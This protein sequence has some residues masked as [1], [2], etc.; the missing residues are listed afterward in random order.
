VVARKTGIEGDPKQAT[1]A[2]GR[3]WDCDKRSREQ[4]T[5]L[6][7]AKLAALK[8]DKEPAIGRKIHRRGSAGEIAPDLYFGKTGGQDGSRD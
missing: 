7:H 6:D 3:R 8:A 5:V 1:L 2:I 4:D